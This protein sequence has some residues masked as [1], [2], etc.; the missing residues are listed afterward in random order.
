MRGPRVVVTFA[1]PAAWLFALCICGTHLQAQIIKTIAGTTFTFPST[2]LSAQNAPLGLVKGVAVD[3][4]GNV[5][6]ADSDNNLVVRFVPGGQMTVVAG[7]GIGGFS[8]DGGPATSA[9]LNSPVGVA[10]DSAGNLYIADGNNA[11]IRQVSGGTIT[12]IAGN[13]NPGFSGDGGLATSA[14]LNFP[15]GVAVDSAGNLFIADQYNQRIRMVSGG[16]ITT[17]AG[18]GT[19]EFSGDGGPATSASLNLR[20]EWL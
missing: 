16:T 1:V 18:N 11:R 19:A 13:G 5:Y 17:E 2:P 3:T 6:A 20:L 8:G 12:T 10:L 7:N 9:S 4:S 14:S 15:A